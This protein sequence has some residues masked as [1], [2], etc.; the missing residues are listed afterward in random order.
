[1]YAERKK[2]FASPF[3]EYVSAIC[4][5]DVG[6]FRKSLHERITEANELGTKAVKYW[7][8][9]IDRIHTLTKEE[10]VAELISQKKIKEKIGQIHRYIS[11]M[12]ING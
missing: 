8:N 12:D 9:E 2:S 7:Q 1:M 6:D 10:A 5:S 11:G 4:S 3:N